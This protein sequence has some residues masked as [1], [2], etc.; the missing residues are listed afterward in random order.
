VSGNVHWDVSDVGVGEVNLRCASAG[1]TD[2]K[3]V[4]LLHGFPECGESWRAVGAVLAQAGC[5][6]VIPDM[7]GYGGSDKP[8]GVAS[9][10]VR[11]LTGDVAGLIGAFGR[12][13]A[14]VVG[15]DWGGVVAWWTA[16]LRPEV[17]ERLGIVNA[18]HPVAYSVAMNTAAQMRRGWYVYFFQIPWLPEQLLALGD[19]RAIRRLFARDNI[20]AERSEP[21]VASLRQPGART[22]ALSYYRAAVRQR[23]SRTPPKPSVILAPTMVVW[24]EHDHFLVPSLSQPPPKL[25]PNVR[26]V[27]LPDATHWAPIDA[28]G[29]V[30]RA[31]LDH[32]A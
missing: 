18:P 22:A 12:Q 9:Y 6:V 5:R 11:K 25:V 16:M 28:V 15:H 26:V 13:R 23:F 24:G 14:H 10:D 21:C 4:V 3:L 19:Y 20:P 29:P 31:L 17:V 7:R 32:L 27:R 30:S 1:P 2:G 8:V